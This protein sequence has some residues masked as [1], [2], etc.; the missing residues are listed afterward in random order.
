M[1]QTLQPY[2]YKDY[3]YLNEDVRDI[4]PVADIVSK[5]SK[6]EPRSAW[7]KGVKCYAL[8]LLD[9]V[10][11]QEFSGW[12]NLRSAMLNGATDWL[13]YSQG[14]CSLVWDEDIA[15]RLCTPSQLK[16]CN[17]G[18]KYLR[19]GTDWIKIQSFA[20]YQAENLI[21]DHAY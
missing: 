10:K 17:G 13:H 3:A 15:E 7:D 21:K 18:R 5:I 9:E 6:I 20:L 8:E 12:Y 11:N 1:S 19:P 14:A 4:L 2:A 16:A